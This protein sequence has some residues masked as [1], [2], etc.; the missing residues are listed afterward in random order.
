MWL[1][2]Q[3]KFWECVAN[4]KFWEGS[5]NMFCGCLWG[6]FNYFWGVLFLFG[7]GGLKQV[8]INNQI[9]YNLGSWI[10]QRHMFFRWFW[11]CLICFLWTRMP[12][13][14]KKHAIFFANQHAADSQTG[15]RLTISP[16]KNQDF[17]TLKC[18]NQWES[19]MKNSFLMSPS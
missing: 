6:L 15:M 4:P 19:P 18:H 1:V 5:D 3:E 10:S 17:E 16:L 8:A 9:S 12:H 2:C 11:F 14:S 7:A 13:Q